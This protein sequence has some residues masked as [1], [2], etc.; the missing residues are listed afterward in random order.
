M[1]DRT[2]VVFYS[3]SSVLATAVVFIL[4]DSFFDRSKIKNKTFYYLSYALYYAVTAVPYLYNNIPML[5]MLLNIGLFAVITLNFDI[6][7]KS[8]IYYI[9][10]IYGA[11]LI[12]E[13]LSAFL[14]GYVKIEL[15]E[16]A[17]IYPYSAMLVSIVI[18]FMFAMVIRN[19]KRQKT[20]IQLPVVIWIG[21]L[22]IP[23]C[24]LIMG[25]MIIT[26]GSYSVNM[27]MFAV[28]VMLLINLLS[29]CIGES[30]ISLYSAKLKKDM[31]E[32]EKKLYI[33]QY[34]LMTNSVNEARA[35]RHDIKKNMN[36]LNELLESERISE[37]QQ[38]LSQYK[39]DLRTDYV[40]CDTGNFMIDSVINYS[41]RNLPS[42]TE[43]EMDID[44]PPQINVDSPTIVTVIGNL[45]ENSIEAL[46]KL[47]GKRKL[48]FRFICSRGRIIIKCE[49]TYNGKCVFDNGNYLTTKTDSSAHG[50]G[51]KNVK[52]ALKKY[53]GEIEIKTDENTF[54]VNAIMF[55]S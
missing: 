45:L 52:N 48:F 16:K 53:N 30:L 42:D 31:L 7:W 37:A 54:I 36:L 24:S 32:Q 12:S 3:I 19:L 51:L 20:E 28:F 26:S 1:A 33:E 46:E 17:H 55:I 25:L 4:M 5:N 10:Q 40:I 14:F 6:N 13:L 44:V 2:F 38:F 39:D 41:L 35:V 8:R 21:T 50:L 9:A 43:L 23:I 15:I 27:Q 47:D 18:A 11:L 49:N 34:K 22:A 29:F